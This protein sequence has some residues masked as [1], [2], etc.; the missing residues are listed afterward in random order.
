VE[1]PSPPM[2]VFV[3]RTPLQLFNAVEARD[4]FHAGDRNRLLCVYRK[5]VDRALMDSLLEGG[6]QAVRFLRLTAVSHQTYAFGLS[7]FLAESRPAATVYVGLPKHV[8][9]HV[10]NTLEPARVVFLDD[11]N[12]VL[13]IAAG[14]AA[15]A[16]RPEY[17]APL[18][19]R[20]TGRRTGLAY[21]ERARFFSLYDL[22]RWIPA[23]R[24]TANDYRCFR[25]KVAG[26]ARGDEVCFIG[27]NLLGQYVDDGAVL[28]RHLG[29]ARAYYKDRPFQYAP[30]RYEDMGFLKAVAR[31]HDFELV[32]FD[33]ILEQAF[34]RRGR[35]PGEVA[36]FRSTAIDTLATL[37]GTDR[38]VFRLPLGDLNSD[39]HREEFARL[40]ADYERRGVPFAE[41]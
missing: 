26:L 25:Q 33:T 27:S 34:L 28:A 8:A 35:V 12:E 39:V 21:L 17:R 13:K 31:E 16:Y 5:P 20:L 23:E 2:N 4:R 19:H 30:H 9:A 38:R 22:S 32:R 36:T 29:R 3:C 40:Y 14:I 41:A 15:G 6:W 11:G 24:C 18:L 10:V 37:Y 7:G 1:A